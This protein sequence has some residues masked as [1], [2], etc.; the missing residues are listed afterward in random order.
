VSADAGGVEIVVDR[1]EAIRLALEGA[2]ASDVIVIAG[3]G[4][5]S[6]QEIQGERRHFSD[7]EQAVT[8]LA[9]RQRARATA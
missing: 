5:E 4:H 8:A 9:Q 6:Y 2:S 7:L 3:K 1:A